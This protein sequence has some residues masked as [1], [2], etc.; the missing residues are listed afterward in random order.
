[1]TDVLH[2]VRPDQ[3]PAVIREMIRHEDQLTNHRLIWLLVGQ[4]FIANAFVTVRNRGGSTYLLLAVAGILVAFSAFVML[5]QSYQAG[6]YLRFLGQQ[7]KTGTLK[8]EHLPLVGWPGNRVENWWRNA[9]WVCRWFRRSRDLIQPWI[10]MRFL[11]IAM[12]VTGLL[13]A[14]SVLSGGATLTVGAILSAVIL[15]TTCVI[16]AWSQGKEEQG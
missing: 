10:L 13:R 15:S 11:F 6:G 3:Y 4:G 9:A 14:G 2:D 7:A 16:V 1:M 12:W 8:E 5:Y